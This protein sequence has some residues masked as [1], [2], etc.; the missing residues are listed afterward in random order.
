MKLTRLLF[1]FFVL[2]L[3]CF[4]SV[5]ATAESSN[6][7]TPEEILNRFLN[8]WLVKQD[9]DESVK[10]FTSDKEYETEIRNVFQVADGEQF[11]I[12]EWTRKVLTMWLFEDHGLVETLG[13]GDPRA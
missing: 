8:E 3:G 13:H 11:D 5:P 6:E 12:D 1:F 9:V 4:L 7:T 10:F 2:M